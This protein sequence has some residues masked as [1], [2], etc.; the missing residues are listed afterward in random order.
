MRTKIAVAL[1]VGLVLIYAWLV[2]DRAILLL[3]DDDLVAKLIGTLLLVFP[4]L[5]GAIV[6]FEIRFGIRT[7]QLR[8]RAAALGV[9]E[10]SLEYRPSGRPTKES[11]LIEF[12]RLQDELQ[13]DS[14]SWTLW[15]RLAEAY[16]ASGDSVRA[17]RSAARAIKLAR[18]ANS[19]H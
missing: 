19:Q 6:F 9:P 13:R 18:A 17:R 2:A 15:L 12:Q 4:V 8:N 5:A 7:E 16:R 3:A 11:A 1:V 10:L 14:E